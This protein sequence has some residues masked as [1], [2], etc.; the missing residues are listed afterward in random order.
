MSGQGPRSALK[1][2]RTYTRKIGLYMDNETVTKVQ[3]SP[4]VRAP[5]VHVEGF[6]TGR[7][8][9]SHVTMH[10]Y[11]VRVRVTS[12]VIWGVSSQ[13]CMYYRVNVSAKLKSDAVRTAVRK[14]WLYL[15][16]HV[17]SY[18]SCSALLLVLRAWSP[19]QLRRYPRIPLEPHT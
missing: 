3:R 12:R 18:Y 4:H 9:T 14:L 2:D 13:G 8:T 16:A 6:T 10:M 15:I 11:V 5:H 7:R 19:L 1:N 17:N